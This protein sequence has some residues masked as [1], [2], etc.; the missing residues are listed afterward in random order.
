[1]KRVKKWLSMILVL[2]ILFSNI[3]AS[4][5]YAEEVTEDVTKEEPGDID[6]NDIP[7]LFH[8]M[9]EML[10]KTVE[11]FDAKTEEWWNSLLTNQR[12]IAEGEY[13][14][15]KTFGNDG[16]ADPVDESLDGYIARLEAG[17]DAGALFASTIYEGLDLETLKE[18]KAEGLTMEDLFAMRESISTYAGDKAYLTT[19]WEN[20]GGGR[21]NRK[22]L[23]GKDAFCFNEEKKF[24]NGASY[25]MV[26]ADQAG[27]TGR[28]A[29]I[30]EFYGESGETNSH[31]WNECQVAIW[32]VQAGCDTYDQGAAYAAAYCRE[33]GITDAWHVSDYMDIVGKLVEQSRGRSGSCYV[34]KA[35]DPANQDIAVYAPIWPAYEPEEEKPEYDSVSATAEKSASI[36]HSISIDNKYAAITGESLAGVVFEVYEDNALKGTITTDANGKG[37]VSWLVSVVK[38]STKSET[39]CSNYNDLSDKEKAKVKGYKNRDDAY[40]A[41][42]AAAQAEALAL[43]NAETGKN[44]TVKVV[45]KEAP[46]GYT[47]TSSSTQTVTLNNSTVSASVSVVNNPWKAKLI[48]DKVNGA[49]GERIEAETVFALYEWNGSAYEVSRNYDIVRMSDG[50][51][52][53]KGKYQQAEQ[54]YLY[55]TRTT[56]L[57]RRRH[58]P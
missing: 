30:V 44:R 55:Y 11:E 12:L 50:T 25:S 56:R 2:G 57:R 7:A 43:A 8:W 52:T 47:L 4:M 37:N 33:R 29:Y 24:P 6:L 35:D 36:T 54:G 18:L 23:D 17:E 14:F 10:P 9:D 27:F 38:S 15:R 58:S 31:W 13:A 19:Q 16:H 26:T 39:Y 41:A 22:F 46:F 34:Y 49:T 32:A 5:A 21:I 45:E 40:N 51:Y 3:S 53:V 20:F 42:L 1:M 48:I 28:A